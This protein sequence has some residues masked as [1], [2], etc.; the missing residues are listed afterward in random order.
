MAANI[1][2]QVDALT[3]A[4]AAKIDNFFGKIDL[5][6]KALD[7][8]LGTSTQSLLDAFSAL[9]NPVAKVQT[10]VVS[11]TEQLGRMRQGT[12]LTTNSM[13]GLQDILQLV[14]GEH[15]PRLMVAAAG[16]QSVMTSLREVTRL[17]GLT[18]GTLAPVVGGVAAAIGLGVIG[19]NE[20]NAASE[21]AER[22][23]RKLGEALKALPRVLG[24]LKTLV[25]TKQLSAEEA[26]GMLDKLGLLQSDPG[27]LKGLK[28]DPSAQ[29]PAG[30]S[31]TNAVMAGRSNLPGY[32]NPGGLN[33]VQEDLVKRGLL[34]K[35]GDKANPQYELSPQ[36]A[37]LEKLREL[38][39]KVALEGLEGFEKEK[40]AAK[41]AYET[42]LAEFEKLAAQAGHFFKP[43]EASAMR[44]QL[45]AGY[46][47]TA[48]D[49]QFNQDLEAHKKAEAAFN[50]RTQEL[51]KIA[52]D[53][54]EKLERELTLIDERE[55][56][57][58]GH[59][60]EAEYAK[61]KFLLDQ[62]LYAGEV[63]EK[64]YTALVEE[65][66]IKRLEAHRREALELKR[67]TEAQAEIDLAR[68]QGRRRLLSGDLDKSELE[69]KAALLE[70][71][72]QENDLLVRNI[73]LNESRVADPTL[74]PTAHLT[75]MR[76]LEELQ[77][78]KAEVQQEIAR[79]VSN[80]TFAGEFRHMLT[81]LKNEWGSWA[82]QMATT[83]K[84]TFNSA[85]TSIGNN[86]TQ[87]IMRT[88]SWGDA[89]RDI[90]TTI[91]SSVINA[92][93]QM[94]VRWVLTHVMMAV[95]GE[96]IAASSA[97]SMAPISAALS[98]IWAEP[99]ALAT[100]ATYSAAADIAPATIAASIGLTQGIAAG[101]SLGGFAQGGFTGAGNPSEIAG[102]VHRGEFVFS[103]P[104]VERIGVGNLEAM[105]A[106]GSRGESGR[107]GEGAGNRISIGVINDR[108]DIPK[109]ARS[110]QGE[111]HILDLVRRNWHTVQR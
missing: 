27:L 32:L 81:E 15:F 72:R 74:D 109:W 90:G 57:A 88:K 65:A 44:Q 104:A 42:A 89:L 26:N 40:A 49:I 53:D 95:A 59:H 28:L 68:V 20:W 86:I 70:L 76:Q 3:E 31:V 111:R 108:S 54:R 10:K 102:P 5:S 33:Q 38:Q 69:K 62:Q 45:A 23:T 83:L 58:R 105:H 87:V 80:G 101:M 103:A 48:Q 107:G 71:L 84:S 66:T 60:Y 97:A 16:T 56:Q 11:A 79:T 51:S 8:S 106:G 25:G 6:A 19:W 93:I 29:T 46:A 61:R 9:D 55:G 75:A 7:K 1:T 92:I 99:A 77:Q 63:D 50:Q 17:T 37:A 52:K 82:Q 110:Q 22:N 94:G 30:S 78:K 100:I 41:D 36:V 13:R 47:G 85:I 35:T 2:I 64:E 12:S 24:D 67:M 18:M 39:K 21:R 98:A 91:L 73:Q 34:T 14:G 96:G 43:Q 4:S